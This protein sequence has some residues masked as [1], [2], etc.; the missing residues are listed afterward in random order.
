MQHPA[1][2]NICMDYFS[3]YLLSIRVYLTICMMVLQA[4]N[5]VSAAEFSHIKLR[6]KFQE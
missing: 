1:A 5:P 4:K 2:K 6:S 3:D